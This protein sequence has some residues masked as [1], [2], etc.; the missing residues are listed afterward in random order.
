[1][2]YE[3]LQAYPLTSPVTPGS[4]LLF[5]ILAP[6]LRD[7]ESPSLPPSTPRILPI[8]PGEHLTPL[9]PGDSYGSLSLSLHSRS[10]QDLFFSKGPQ[11][12]DPLS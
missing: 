7:P 3:V 5:K 4:A 10:S 12:P 8:F 9:S 11:A 2:V 6:F 1:M